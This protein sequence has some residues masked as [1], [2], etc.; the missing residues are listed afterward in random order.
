MDCHLRLWDV[1]QPH[2]PLHTLRTDGGVAVASPPPALSQVSPSLAEGDATQPGSSAEAAAAGH[3]DSPIAAF[4]FLS[5]GEAPGGEKLVAVTRAGGV[6]LLSVGRT[7]PPYT[8]TCPVA[9]CWGPR[10]ELLSAFSPHIPRLRAE[11]APPLTPPTLPTAA[12]GQSS[13]RSP[14]MSPALRPSASSPPPPT[15]PPSESVALAGGSRDPV[16]SWRPWAAGL[17]RIDLGGPSAPHAEVGVV[18]AAAARASD[19]P[20]YRRAASAPVAR[21]LSPGL[22]SPDTPGVCGRGRR[23]SPAVHSLKLAPSSETPPLSHTYIPPPSC[24][25]WGGKA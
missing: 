2:A 11:H 21:L 16:R 6:S 25:S 7:P 20:T 3:A 15:P 13:R 19:G 18:P 22:C 10:D 9:L 12:L 24:A 4:A 17:G 8:D 23:T 5:A 14:P 1:M